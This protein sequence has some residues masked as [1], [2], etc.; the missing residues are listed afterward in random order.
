[1]A[2]SVVCVGGGRLL[3]VWHTP[4][5]QSMCPPPPLQVTDGGSVLAQ[6]QF[7]NFRH[8]RVF[9]LSDHKLASG[10]LVVRGRGG[11]G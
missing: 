6:R 7:H 8:F 9:D 1:M 4:G 10:P 11:G 2:L 5:R 3:C